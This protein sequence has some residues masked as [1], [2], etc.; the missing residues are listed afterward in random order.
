MDVTDRTRITENVVAGDRTSFA[1][2]FSGIGYMERRLAGLRKQETQGGPQALTDL[3]QHPDCYRARSVYSFVFPCA[4]IAIRPSH[5]GESITGKR[6]SQPFSF[7]PASG[8][9]SDGGEPK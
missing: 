4:G 8:K 2:V 6:P 1:R 3:V 9:M 7:K 5:G